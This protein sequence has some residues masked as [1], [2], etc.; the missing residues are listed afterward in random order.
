MQIK[1]KTR[2]KVEQLIRNIILFTL[3]GIPSLTFCQL[4]FQLQ[5]EMVCE[6][7]TIP[8]GSYYTITAQVKNIG[9]AGTYDFEM[10]FDYT[11]G[12]FITV[13]KKECS[14][15]FNTNQI[16]TLTFDLND[17]IDV[18]AGT[19]GVF[20]FVAT[21]ACADCGT[22]GGCYV[23]VA[24]GLGDNPLYVTVT[25]EPTC[26]GWDVDPNYQSVPAAG[27]SY[28]AQ[29]TTDVGGCSYNLTFNN[30]WID[31]IG[32]T[33]DGYFDYSVEPNLGSART[34]TISINNVTDGIDDIV[35]LTIDQAAAGGDGPGEP[36][37]F[38]IE[39]VTSTTIYLNWSAPDDEG[40]GIDYYDVKNCLTGEIV[41]TPS[42]SSCTISFLIPNTYYG[43]QVRTV[44]EDGNYSTYTDC[45]YEY[46]DPS[47]CELPSGLTETSVTTNSA[48][49]QWTD[50]EPDYNIR[51]KISG[52]ATWTTTTSSTNSKSIT[53][54]SS[55]TT[56]EW[57]VEFNCGADVSGYTS[58]QYFTTLN[59]PSTINI[60][61]ENIPGW[62]RDNE[63]GGFTGSVSVLTTPPGDD[64]R[65]EVYKNGGAIPI[66]IY[67]STGAMTFNFNSADFGIWDER[68]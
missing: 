42:G 67:Y 24:D 46:T 48:I 6:P 5:D 45:D 21:S 59:I 28:D 25:D 29:V 19:Y 68:G 33:G 8:N 53:G 4:S 26:T 31:F 16:K 64:W 52:G 2:L 51:Y 47:P 1:S 40:A 23:Q 54:L 43:F 9:A 36:E 27:G 34:G 63:P 37:S 18:T 38:S 30:A 41:A 49:L 13:V 22:G 32:F 55:N 10:D 20:L 11:W 3:I 17:P 65:L 56:Y 61:S 12:G 58:S 60:T 66:E 14:E 39:D 57:Q 35:I 15:Y 44:D 7:I 62:Q 50:V